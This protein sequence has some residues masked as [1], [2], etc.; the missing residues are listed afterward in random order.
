MANTL[1]E[2]VPKL[3]AQ[4]LL[5]LRQMAIMP[6]LV[7]RRYEVLAGRQGSTIDVPIPS[8]ITAQAV[9]PAATPPS[10]AD[11][12][13]TSVAI[14]LDQWYEAPFYLTDKDMLEIQDG[15]IPMVASEAVKS[16]ANNVDIFLLTLGKK[17]YGV[18]GVAG[19]T[20]FGNEKTTD[21]SS[22]RTVLNKQLA[23]MDPR[24]V[25][26]SPEAE[27]SALNVRAFQD[28]SFGGGV[29]A[30]L[31]GNLNNKLGFRWWMDQNVL[32]H[33]A[34]TGANYLTNVATA[35]TAG[36]KTITVDTGTGTIL[37]GDIITFATHT[38]TYVVTSALAANV[39]SIEPG[40]VVAVANNVA[41]LAPGD[42][43]GVGTHVLNLGFHRDAIAFA[44]RPLEGSSHPGSIIDA[45]TD[46]ISGLTLRLE[47]TREHKRDRF[48][49]D[50]LYGGE[51]V[52][53]E[54]GARLLG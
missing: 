1:T 50:I 20:P 39:F 28:A 51:V 14:P 53:R 45:A 49:F 2:T 25:V 4:G 22:L 43:G 7:N 16:L 8:A 48:S 32:T 11:I 42:T 52:R 23:D 44:T 27:G 40:L 26:L 30:L 9:S 3:L 34:G 21:A 5:A 17:F 37:V 10:T 31:Q 15:T 46:P 54:L 33:T 47:V 13:P 12:A 35:I 36:S 38:Q 24:H 6:Q 19:T 41:I 18:A 29:Q